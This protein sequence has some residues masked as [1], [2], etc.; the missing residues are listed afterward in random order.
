[1]ARRPIV[2]TNTLDDVAASSAAPPTLPGQTVWVV[3]ANSLIFQV[4][5]ALPEMTS[6]RGEPV[7]AVFG[8][9]RDMLYLLEQKKPDYLFVAFDGPEQTFRHEMY[10]DYKAQRGEMPVDLVPQFA[11]IRRVLAAL[12]MPMLELR[13][14]TRPTTCWPRSP[15]RS[16]ELE[17][18]CY[19]VTGDKDCRQLITERVKVYNIRKDQMYDAAALEADWGVRPEQVVD[20]QALVGDSVDNVPG[21]PLIG[22]K[23]AGEYLQKY[24]TLDELLAH[25]DEL[26]KGKRKDNLIADARTGAVEP[27][28]GA[29]RS[30]RADRDRLERRRASSGVDQRGAGR[31][32]RR[33]RLSQPGAKSIRRCPSGRPRQRPEGRLPD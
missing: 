11:P 21:V 24:D 30:P 32:V 27:R 14:L 22:P 1:M 7:S 15:T 13:R 23:I 4:F 25:A 6:P 20:F 2:R 33:A 31:A 8:F 10:D 18:E 26:P 17:G 28:A 5:H 3:D 16:N 19:L 9:T 12:G 29:A